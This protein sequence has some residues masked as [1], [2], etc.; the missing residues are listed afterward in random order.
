MA[1]DD[2]RVDAGFG[3]RPVRTS[4][5]DR[6]IEKG[7]ARH[8]RSRADGELAD[9]ETGCI[10]H[11]EQCIAS[12]AVEHAFTH[13]CLGTAEAL[14]CRLE[15]EVDRPVEITRLG[16]IAGGTQQH[17]GMAVMTA[18]MHASIMARSVL[19][20]VGFRDRQ[21]IHIGPQPHRARRI[22]DPKPADD[23]GLAD[24]AMDLAAELAK[25]RGHQI[26]S[27]PFL[28][29]ELGMGMNVAPPARQ[30]VVHLCDTVNNWHG[31]PV[32]LSWARSA[33][34]CNMGVFQGGW[35]A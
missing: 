25:L 12:E 10:V 21:R 29:P 30:I 18:S 5:E 35:S 7:T 33:L 4:A 6:D 31:R 17:R 8:H 9:G 13:H 2:D 19:E 3:T 20:A 34:S 28:E 22:A 24:P 1:A 15:D 16:E 26:G 14:F 11:P 32:S 27:A 23:T